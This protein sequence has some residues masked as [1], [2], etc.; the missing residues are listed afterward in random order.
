[1]HEVCVLLMDTRR[2]RELARE[3]T[4]SADARARSWGQRATEV[5]STHS[6]ALRELREV[7]SRQAAG[8]VW[9]VIDVQKI[10]LPEVRQLIWDC[11]GECVAAQREGD[12]SRHMSE[13]GG[14]G[15]AQ[16]V[17]FQS[18]KAEQL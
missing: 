17:R 12:E 14:Y 5:D 9:D 1:M 16:G 8:E 10:E 2:R 15:A 4:G 6:A 18:E 7:E 3:T 13:R 11:T